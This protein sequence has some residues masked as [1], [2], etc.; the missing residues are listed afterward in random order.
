MLLGTTVATEKLYA[1]GAQTNLPSLQRVVDAVTSRAAGS[2][3]IHL[4]KSTG[5][6]KHIY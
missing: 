4:R 2:Y 5:S 6:G 1:L 3:S